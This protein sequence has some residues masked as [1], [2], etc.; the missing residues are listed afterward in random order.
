MTTANKVIDHLKKRFNLEI[1]TRKGPPAGVDPKTIMT[2]T[3]PKN[4]DAELTHYAIRQ[5]KYLAEKPID[6]EL[7]KKHPD[8]MFTVKS[9]N[10]GVAVSVSD[11]IR[12]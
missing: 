11:D 7:A 2:A 4:K 3:D 9:A 6:W 5:V 10:D 1:V 12:G 8:H